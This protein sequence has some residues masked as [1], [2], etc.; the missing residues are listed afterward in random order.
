MGQ[1]LIHAG[2]LEYLECE[3]SGSRFG[4]ISEHVVNIH[5]GGKALLMQGYT[6]FMQRV[7]EGKVNLQTKRNVILKI[8]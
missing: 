4:Q 3:G 6:E 1:Q 5:R 8:T 7:E 2:L